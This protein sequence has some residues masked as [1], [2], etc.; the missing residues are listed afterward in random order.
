VKKLLASPHSFDL[1]EQYCCEKLK[2]FLTPYLER[3]SSLPSTPG[4][5]GLGSRSTSTNNVAGL[6]LSPGGTQQAIAQNLWLSP[7][8]DCH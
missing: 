6:P 5:S 2:R 1:N 4:K 8:P 3:A 7:P